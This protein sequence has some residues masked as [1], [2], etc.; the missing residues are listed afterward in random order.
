MARIMI[1]DDSAMSRRM[2]R[3]I[4]ESG[5]HEVAEAD[6]GLAALELYFLKKPE[7]VMLDLIMRGMYGLDV[8]KKL[9]EMDP[10]VRVIV[11]SADI[12]TSTQRMAY[13]SGAASFVTKPFERS[14]VLNAVQT[15]LGGESNASQ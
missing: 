5:A 1:V 6:D 15:A 11:A 9:R 13:E 12:Q 10:S 7:V 14:A 2:L 3:E 8:L 4:L